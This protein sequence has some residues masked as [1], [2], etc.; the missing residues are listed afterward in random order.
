MSRL[1]NL[2]VVHCSDTYH[3]MD[4]GVDEIRKWHVQERGWKDIGYHFVIRRDGTL[5]LG[6]DIDKDGAHTIGY[7]KNSV[8]VCLIGGKGDD[9]KAEN[10][11]TPDQ[12]QTLK[13]TLRMIMCFHPRVT[14]H[15]HREFAQKDC[16]SFDVQEWMRMAKI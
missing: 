3:D 10:N 16:P 4:I 9:G 5:E 12:F 1:I 13:N 2:V 8:G 11:F 15:G 6:R 14:I 7:N